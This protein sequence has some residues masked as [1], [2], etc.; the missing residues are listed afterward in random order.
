MA[1]Q[2]VVLAFFP[3]EAFADFAAASLEDWDDA[4][5]RVKLDSIGV[6]ALDD[7]GHLKVE[8]LGRR[9]FGTGAGLG[10]AVALI[11]PLGLGAVLAGGAL[12]AL[13]RKGLGLPDAERERIGAQLTGGRAAVGVLVRR[14]L[15]E[16]VVTKLANL[17][18]SV[19]THTVS[20]ELPVEPDAT[21]VARPD[22]APET[23]ADPTSG[24]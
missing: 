21:Q 20:D 19:E 4:E 8:K 12:G 7:L 23:G 14:N 10:L 6:L 9:T 16:A 11:T 13:H 3:T 22:A 15:A 24:T 18:G 5:S 17:G 2:T 1:Q